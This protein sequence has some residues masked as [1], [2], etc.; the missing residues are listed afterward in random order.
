MKEDETEPHAHAPLRPDGFSPRE[1]EAVE[2]D[3][4][5]RR[6]TEE[7]IPP[8]LDHLAE[9]WWVWRACQ[10]RL[11]PLTFCNFSSTYAVAKRFTR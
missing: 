1:P 6:E 10:P 3:A 11:L 9:P 7:E 8:R 5:Y 4:T 2:S